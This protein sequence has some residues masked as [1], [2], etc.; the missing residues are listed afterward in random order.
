MSKRHLYA[1]VGLFGPAGL[2][3]AF[4]LIALTQ[5]SPSA[6]AG[7]AGPALSSPRY[8]LLTRGDDLILADTHTADAWLF[9]ASS[10]TSLW[11]QLPNPLRDTNRVL[12]SSR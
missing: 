9:T 8:Q 5:R 3:L 1:F 6:A 4:A 11:I 7:N 12:H 2:V 10:R